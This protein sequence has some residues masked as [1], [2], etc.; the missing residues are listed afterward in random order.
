MP[1]DIRLEVMVTESLREKQYTIPVHSESDNVS[2]SRSGQGFPCNAMCAKD[3]SY[4]HVAL[5]AHCMPIG[6][7]N[8]GIH[9]MACEI[10]F[11]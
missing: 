11:K 9:Y 2:C 8:N 3:Y 6:L 10:R 4:I 5:C 7:F 1:R